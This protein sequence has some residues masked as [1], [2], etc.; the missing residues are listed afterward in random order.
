MATTD[1]TS[2]EAPEVPDNVKVVRWKGRDFWT[3]E[4]GEGQVLAITRMAN[5]QLPKDITLERMISWLNRAPRLAESLCARD[6]DKDW[7][8]DAY[9][10]KVVEVHE[11]PDFLAEIV[12]AWWGSPNREQRRAATTKK[13]AVKKAARRVA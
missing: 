9:L 10:D 4:P 3:L 6:E 12:M 5:L 2:T 1:G 7:L 8:E 11:I 13:A